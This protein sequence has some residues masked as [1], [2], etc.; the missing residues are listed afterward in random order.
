MTRIS[1][2]ILGAP[3]ALL[4]TAGVIAPAVIFF[5][6]SFFGFSMY[7]IQ[8]GFHLDWYREILTGTVYRMVAL[9]TLAIALPTTIASVI[10]G[11]A[12]AY[13]IV[14]DAGRGGRLIFML[15]TV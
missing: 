12:I 13:H 4:L 2:L 10:G 8:P 9:N 6:Y 1:A 14:F 11:Y 5:V 7:E 15:V 3:L